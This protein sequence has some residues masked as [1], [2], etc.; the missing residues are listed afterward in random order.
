MSCTA[1]L[2]T[3]YLFQTCHPLVYV[4]CFLGPVLGE[5]LNN[6]SLFTSLL[7]NLRHSLRLLLS[8][9]RPT[10]C[11]I[12]IWSLTTSLAF[13]TVAFWADGFGELRYS[14]WVLRATS[15]ATTA[16]IRLTPLY[17]SNY[18]I[19][20][21]VLSVSQYHHTPLQFFPAYNFSN[22]FILFVNYVISIFLLPDL[23]RTGSCLYLWG[24]SLMIFCWK[25]WL[26]ILMLLTSPY[27]EQ[28]GRRMGWN[29]Y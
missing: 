1:Q 27:R 10:A 9:Q 23:L 2:H 29:K 19:V 5:G 13:I 21:G 4:W 7:H 22:S 12:S 6:N 18:W 24:T 14:F 20:P 15:K 17:T 3:W 8:Y 25:S 11:F 28:R 16:Y 26:F